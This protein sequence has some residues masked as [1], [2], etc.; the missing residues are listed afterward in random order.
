MAEIKITEEKLTEM[1]ATAAAAAA[2]AA[3]E[4][5]R[6]PPLPS[7]QER[8]EAHSEMVHPK[9]RAGEEG[10]LVPCVSPDTGST[11]LA[12]VV[13]SRKYPHGRVV[14]LRDYKYPPE[15]EKHAADADGTGDE[16]GRVPHGMVMQTP[17]GALTVE[18][19][20]WRWTEFWQKDI[21]AV[22]GLPLRPSYRAT[23]GAKAAE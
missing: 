7:E 13:K 12:R 17:Q 14:E 8:F 3:I 23:P 22:V 10:E 1:V 5:L 15:A 21:R 20:H 18:Y 6:G 4:G 9:P 2:K 16:G 11:F 19:K